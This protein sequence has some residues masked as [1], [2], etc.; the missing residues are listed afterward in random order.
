[1]I[2]YVEI[3]PDTGFVISTGYSKD[4]GENDVSVD[5]DPY[6]FTNYQMVSGEFVPRPLAPLPTSNEN[7]WEVMDCP[8]GTQ[9]RVIDV[10]NGDVLGEVITT[11]EM[12]SFTFSLTDE[13]RYQV[14]VDPPDPYI[15]TYLDIEIYK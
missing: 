7:G 11:V 3:D 15:S 8:P 5:G 6:D 10:Q 2:G 9:I 1:M 4:L 13:G 14:V 12:P